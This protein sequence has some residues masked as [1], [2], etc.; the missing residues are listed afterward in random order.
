MKTAFDFLRS[1]KMQ[2]SLHICT[3]LYAVI[4]L[5]SLI[6]YFKNLVVSKL[7]R[8][9]CALYARKYSKTF[10]VTGHLFYHSVAKTVCSTCSLP[11]IAVSIVIFLKVR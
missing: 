9:V 4:F 11:E 10:L 1:A 7:S 2:I 8:P 5:V 3:I 6:I